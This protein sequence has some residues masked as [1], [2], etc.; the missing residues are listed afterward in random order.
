MRLAEQ[1][2]RWFSLWPQARKSPPLSKQMRTSRR[3]LPDPPHCTAIMSGLSCGVRGEEIVD[4]LA[5][6]HKQA[7]VGNPHEARRNLDLVVELSRQVEI[8]VHAEPR[9]RAVLA[10]FIEDQPLARHDVE[11]A[12]CDR[13][14]HPA[15][16]RGA[17]VLRPAALVLRP[18]AMQHEGVRPAAAHVALRLVAVASAVR[19][20]GRTPGECEHVVVEGAGLVALTA[21][22]AAVVVLRIG[23]L[24]LRHSRAGRKRNGGDQRCNSGDMHFHPAIPYATSLRTQVCAASP[25][26]LA[27]LRQAYLPIT[28]QGHGGCGPS[29]VPPCGRRTGCT[30]H[31]GSGCGRRRARSRPAGCPCPARP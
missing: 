11:H 14:R 25:Y 30:F 1:S 12:F 16:V 28:P 23:P 27:R 6:A 18:Q 5:R 10:V 2:R 19:A 13:S 17:A 7:V 26:R 29:C 31:W 3:R 24:A 22:G 9:A 8:A 4:Q 20:I 15:A 21:I